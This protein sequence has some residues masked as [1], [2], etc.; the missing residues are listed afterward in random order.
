M[1]TYETYKDSGIDWVGDIPKSWNVKRLK[2]IG[3]LYSGLSGKAGDDFSKEPVLGHK[4]F[5][6]FTNVANN[7][8]IVGD[9]FGYVRID[10]NENQNSVEEGDLFFLMSSENQE[11]V[12]KCSVLNENFGE[13]YLNSFCKGFR[14]NDT[15]VNSHFI[16]YLLNSSSMSQLLSLEGRG[17]TRINLRMEGVYNLPVLVPPA[18]EQTQIAK[19][20]DCKT[21]QIDDLISKKEKLIELLK[22][23][24]IAIINQAV[25]K[26]LDPNVPMKDSGIEWLG[27]IPE[28]WEVPKLWHLLMMQKLEIQD[29]NHGSLYPK[30]EEFKTEGVPFIKPRDIRNGGVNF[31][32]CDCLTPQHAASLRIG[33]SLPNDILLVNRGGTIGRMARMPLIPNGLD[34]VIINP[35]MTYLRCRD[36]L[37]SDFTY[38]QCLSDVFQESLEQVKAFG[39][40]FSFLGLSNMGDFPFVLP[41]L[42]EQKDISQY[43]NEKLDATDT[44]IDKMFS[45]IELLKEYKTALISEVVT[46]KVDVRDVEV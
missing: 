4:P 32:T 26:G 11:D 33:F 38:F 43:I 24:R 46:G 42:D 21:A 16:N 10:E 28:H 7:N 9:N 20:L 44:S 18:E 45:E 8:K 31:S 15:G 14:P 13:L 27:E 6:N 2:N 12:G 41:P 35:Q 1:K 23:E 3:R 29:G 39:S 34:Y 19:Y 22:E 40:T 30:Q 17:F 37:D 5:I 25:T 36:G